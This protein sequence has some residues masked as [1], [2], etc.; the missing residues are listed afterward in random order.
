MDIN[1][2]K[3]HNQLLFEDYNNS[4]ESFI[5]S[6]CDSTKSDCDNWESFFKNIE[7]WKKKYLIYSEEFTLYGVFGW[8]WEALHCKFNACEDDNYISI[9]SLI[10]W[11]INCD[12]SEY[13]FYKNK[14]F[15]TL[16]EFFFAADSLTELTKDSFLDEIFDQYQ[17]SYKKFEYYVKDRGKNN[18]KVVEELTVQ[19]TRF[20]THFNEFKRNLSNCS[21][22]RI[23][24]LGMDENVWYFVKED[25]YIQVILIQDFM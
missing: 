25:D 8:Y 19:Y 4:L 18:P 1:A 20:K 15:P 6:L 17:K 5:N 13:S 16:T 23:N 21:V 2:A 24:N 12:D 14:G 3:N 7:T 22:L 10:C 11:S 9:I